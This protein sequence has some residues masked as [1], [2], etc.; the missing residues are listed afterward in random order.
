MDYLS[1][2]ITN[3]KCFHKES[4]FDDIKKVN[5]IVG[6]NNSGKSSLIDIVEAACKKNYDFPQSTWRKGQHP[7]VL[8]SKRLQESEVY[9]TFP[10]NTHGGKIGRNH[11][12]Y[13][14]Q[15][16][17]RVIK[18]LKKGSSAGKSLSCDLIEVDDS[19]ITPLLKNSDNYDQKICQNLKIFLEGKIFKRLQAER[20]ISPEKAQNGSLGFQ[21]NGAGLTNSIQ[22]FINLS[23]LPSNLVE[24]DLLNA[25]NSVFSRDA[26]FTDIVC[27][28]HENDTW[29]IFLEEE[30]KGRIALS[31]SGSGL[32]TVILVLSS[33]I[34]TP[35]IEKKPL[36]DFVFAFEE[37]ENNIHPA[38]LRRLNEYVYKAAI[39][40]DFVYF[41]TTHSN[42]LIDQF[43]KQSDAQIV[44]VKH[45]NGE[46]FTE[47]ATTYIHNNGILDDLDIRASDLLQ[48]NGII[49]VEGPSDRIYLNKWID[50]WSDGELKEGTHYQIIFY[51]GRLLSHLS[52]MTPDE[53]EE[54][55]SILN[56][57]RNAI[58]LID[59][60]KRHKQT[61]INSTKERIESEFKSIGALCWITKGKEIENYIP[62]NASKAFFENKNI[63]STDRYADYFS[64]IDSFKNK[65]GEKYRKQKSVLAENIIKH[66]KMQD[67][68]LVLDLDQ[69]M[70]EVC[71][72]I[73]QWNR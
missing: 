50:L 34:L 53:R 63:T 52:G 40:H 56:T 38:L 20:D 9:S 7:K 64:H 43:S 51:G 28:L 14:A 21:S 25:I 3:Y 66:M 45:E 23:S 47:T 8:F 67:L 31:Q 30:E 6:R 58:I 49:W 46:S 39:E 10:A 29:E 24:K 36:N 48:A 11:R 37:L 42:T 73:K 44:H 2:R 26:H 55:I 32:K 72:V 13:G 18:F 1:I 65:I 22:S 27:Q 71:S 62:G 16:L 69:K 19:G 15:Y 57:N 68:K 54:G 35:H 60:D 17:G 41:L 12:E 33:L 59:S 61:P 5:L 4:G 70:N